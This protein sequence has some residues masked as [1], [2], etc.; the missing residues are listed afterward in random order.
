MLEEK[1]PVESSSTIM[2]RIYRSLK[3]AWSG[4]NPQHFRARRPLGV[5]E[6][7]LK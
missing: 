2:R 5:K 6:N 3:L 1:K 7:A 4:F